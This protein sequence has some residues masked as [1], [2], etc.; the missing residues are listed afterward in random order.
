MRLGSR[1]IRW[2]MV[3]SG[4]LTCTMLQAA[5]APNAALVSYFGSGLEGPGAE[6]VT[7]NWGILIALI[8]GMLIYA[9]FRPALQRYTLFVAGISKLAFMG[10]LLGFSPTGLTT[11]A[12]TALVVDALMVV[13]FAM[14][15]LQAPAKPAERKQ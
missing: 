9:A 2:V 3:I 8:G 14:I 13:L 4:L 6:V 10:L 7:R 15:V 12:V 5:V 11:S 1:T